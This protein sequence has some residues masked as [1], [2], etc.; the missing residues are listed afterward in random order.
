M[1]FRKKSRGPVCVFHLE[2]GYP[3]VRS[4]FIKS[5]ALLAPTPKSYSI[6]EGD[7]A[8]ERGGILHLNS[9]AARA[10]LRDPI[11]R[12]RSVCGT[13]GLRRKIRSPRR[14][15]D[16]SAICQADFAGGGQLRE[17]RHDD[18]DDAVR[19]DLAACGIIATA[20]ANLKA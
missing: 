8:R 20:S 16:S 10:G 19:I 18:E 7:L 17:L 2:T 9:L 4:Q 3:R 14:A 6:P 12:R 5:S 11:R 1:C 13:R 15:R